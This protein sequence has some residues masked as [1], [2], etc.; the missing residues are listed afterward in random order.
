MKQIGFGNLGFAWGVRLTAKVPLEQC[1]GNKNR[2]V[3]SG[4]IVSGG[5]GASGGSG[6]LGGCPGVERP[7]DSNFLSSL[8]HE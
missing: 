6:G 2:P 8:G 1:S 4:D 3:V 5:P 7:P